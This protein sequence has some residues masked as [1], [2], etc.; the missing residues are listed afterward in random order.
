ME[1]RGL[2]IHRQ[3]KKKK[4]NL[5]LELGALDIMDD[6]SNLEENDKVR[7]LELLSELKL[8]LHNESAILNEKARMKWLEQGDTNSKYFQSRIRWKRVSNKLKGVELNGTWC[9]DPTKVR[10]EVRQV[11]EERFST[12]KL[13][14]INLQNI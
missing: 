2:W 13:F 10:E 12:P 3:K 9:E 11:F 7:R 14:C 4:Q 5:L 6:E 1:Q 8:L